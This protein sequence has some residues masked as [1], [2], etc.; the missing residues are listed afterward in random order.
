M[1]KKAKIAWCS[2]PFILII[3]E[4][5]CLLRVLLTYFQIGWAATFSQGLVF[6]GI[7]LLIGV[8]IGMILLKRIYPVKNSDLLKERTFLG[9]FLL[10]II[11][12]IV[13]YL[14]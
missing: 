3:F 1:G 5:L 8:F 6:L 2:L 14:V 9:L 4:G 7:V 11:L 12:G 10:M 13:L